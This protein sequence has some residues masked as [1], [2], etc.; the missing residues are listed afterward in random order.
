ME[1]THEVLSN[2]LR[3]VLTWVFLCL[4]AYGGYRFVTAISDYGHARQYNEAVVRER[5][6]MDLRGVITERRRGLPR[7]MQE[8]DDPSPAAATLLADLRAEVLRYER[9]RQQQA[10]VLHVWKFTEEEHVPSG[11]KPLHAVEHMFPAV[12]WEQMLEYAQSK[13]ALK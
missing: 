13:N 1:K 3:S 11:E 12:S 6:L 10:A 7:A 2:T 5:D 9:L 8:F 4:L